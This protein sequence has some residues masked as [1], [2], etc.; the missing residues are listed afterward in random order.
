MYS[1]AYRVSNSGERRVAVGAARVIDPGA[2]PGLHQAFHGQLEGRV[3]VRGTKGSEEVWGDPGCEEGL[4]VM[5]E[6]KSV[7]ERIASYRR[8]RGLTQEVLAGQVGRSVGWLSLIERGD[9]TVETINDLLE[10]ARVLKVTPGD[11]IGGIEF[12]P[13]GGAPLDPPRGVHAVSRALFEVLPPGQEPPDL[14]RLR[15]GVE[16]AGQLTCSGKYRATAI[17]LPDLLVNVRAAVAHEARGARWCLAA[18]YHVASRFARDVGE[19]DLALLTAERAGAAAQA[20]RDQLLVAASARDLAFALLRR[21]WLD[22]AG[23]VCSNGADLLAPTDA[24]PPE[25]WALWGSLQVTQAVAAVRGGD[26]T[27]AWQLLRDARAAAERVGPGRNDYYEA[28]GPANVGAHEVA[29]ALESGDAV[30]ALR[31]ADHVE[32]DELPIPERRA[33]V[34]IDF[35]RAHGWRRDDGA[36]VAVLREAERHSPE[37]VHFSVKAHE[38]VR[39]LLRRERRSRT[40][41]LRGLAQRLGVT[42]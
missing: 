5:D 31:L 30:E 9:R 8:R 15:A 24:T 3:R 16:Q 23:A 39:V 38:L 11:L 21:G 20:S 22:E 35:A 42:D 1:H 26:G 41:G 4:R 34:L 6:H 18:A 25:G 29:V 12:P 10:L 32:I 40:P 28:F 33:H 27:Y 14:A 13:N 2:Q 36:A 37:D 7:G 19:Q 17:M